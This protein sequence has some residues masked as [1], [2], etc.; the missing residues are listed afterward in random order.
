[1]GNVLHSIVTG[2]GLPAWAIIAIAYKVYR[3]AGSASASLWAKVSSGKAADKKTR[4]IASLWSLAKLVTLL[5]IWLYL[6]SILQNVK[7][8]ILG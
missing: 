1:M 3:Y 4:A 6:G 2:N 5:L 8:G 7:P